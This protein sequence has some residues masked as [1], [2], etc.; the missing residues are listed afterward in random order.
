MTDYR[1]IA[2]GICPVHDTPLIRMKDCGACR[3]CGTGWSLTPDTVSVHLI[4]RG[5]WPT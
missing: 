4:R 3:E 5:E 2:E 1:K